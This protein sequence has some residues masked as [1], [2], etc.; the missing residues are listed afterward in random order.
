MT[1]H[2]R[3]SFPATGPLWLFL[4]LSGP[5]AAQ[6][7]MAT[8]RSVP[9]PQVRVNDAFF[10]P[11]RATNTAVTLDHALRQLE[12]V[13]TLGNYD[14][15]AAGATE[16]YRGPVYQDSDAYKALEAVAFALADHR[17]PALEVRLDAVIARMARAQQE[18]GYLNTAYLVQRPGP[19]FSNLRDHHELY[20]AGHLF[21]AA[22]AH[23]RATGKRTLLDIATR[24]ADLIVRTFGDGK[25]LGGG[26]PG[27]PE[28]ELALVK[29]ADATGNGDY[30]DLA[31]SFVRRRGRGWFA[32]EH[33]VDP[34]TVDLSYWLDHV[35]VVQMQRIA[36]HAVRAAYLMAG[37]TDVAARTGDGEL[38]AAVQRIWTNT[39][40]KNV[41]VT[42]GIGPSAHNEGFTTDYDLP[43]SSAYQES[44][45]SIALVLWA[46]RL[47]LVSRDPTFADIVETALYNAI[48]AGV[49]LD[50]TRFFYTNPL[51]SRG[52][53]HRRGWFGCA[54][55]PPNLART[56]AALGS[57][58]YATSGDELFV[59]LL[60]KGEV[61]AEVAGGRLALAIDTE[62]PWQGD[63][64][65]RVIVAPSAPVTLKLRVPG[66]CAGATV[67]MAGE[68]EAR[69]VGPGYAAV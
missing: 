23:Y 12:E 17:D 61:D 1:D 42:G 10:S 28:I 7:A 32:T 50:G 44:C 37:A 47:N 59:N 25:S 36:G 33:G 58:A 63:V 54:C 26:Y 2:R 21:E 19:R 6:E 52:D 57:Y 18:D 49:Q 38:L 9:F 27:H 53:H 15:A 51:A 31:D 16:G 3:G 20:C 11:R 56:F 40:S 55:C 39:I 41:F 60:L 24:F 8:L 29:L 43:T 66:W 35:P 46:H 65:L 69:A 4:V 45:A 48:P 67:K 64:S 14:L 30:L 5:A 34:K 62:Y 13:G 22:V 68:A